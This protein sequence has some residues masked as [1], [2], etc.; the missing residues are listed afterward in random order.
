METSAWFQWS[1]WDWISL[2][3]LCAS[4]VAGILSG[5]V[6]TAFALASW[7]IAFLFASELGAKL[8]A[9]LTW[10]QDRFVL[11][12]IAFFLLLLITRVIGA[13]TASALR[14]A[15]LGL[16]D[17]I[18]GFALGLARAMLVLAFCALLAQRLGLMQH[19]SFDRAHSRA[20]WIWL[21]Q[22]AEPYW[23]DMVQGGL[24]VGS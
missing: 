12:A 9:W 19:E 8:A 10:P 3:V 1:L 17:R 18:A 24:R 15:G 11:M 23:A 4:A 5:L 22:A 2:L 20:L 16:V 14:W 21:V 7:L 6:K 13:M